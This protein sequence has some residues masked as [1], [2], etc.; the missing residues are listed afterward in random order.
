MK[1]IFACVLALCV[2]AAMLG[3]SL[4]VSNRDAAAEAVLEEA[5]VTEPA[6]AGDTGAGDTGAA[7]VDTSAATGDTGAATGDTGT[8]DTGA[9]AGDTGTGDTGTAAGDTGTATGD[10]GTGDTGTAAGDAG[11]STGVEA[12]AGDSG[13]ADAG[14]GDTQAGEADAGETVTDGSAEPDPTGD[15]A[16]TDGTEDTGETTDGD[17]AVA[18]DEGLVEPAEEE[19][20][21]LPEA[22]VGS[23]PAWIQEGAHRHYGELGELLP[24]AMGSG[25]A[26]VLCTASVIELTGYSVDSL[27]GVSFGVDRDALGGY[28]SGRSVIVSKLNPSGDSKSGVVFVWVGYPESAPTGGDALGEELDLSDEEDVLETEIMVRAE[29]YVAEEACAPVF[30]LVACPALGEGVTYAVQVNGGAAQSIAGD[31]YAPTASGEYRF[32]V[33]DAG[34]TLLAQSIP[35]TVNFAARETAPVATPDEEEGETADTGETD[36]GDTLLT[37]EAQ[38]G[39][40]SLAEAVGEEPTPELTVRAY[41]YTEGVSTG[42]TPVFA[43]SGAP[44]EGGYSYGVSVNGGSVVPLLTDQ[45]APTSSGEFTFVFFLL[46]ADGQTVGQSTSYHV[47]LD[48]AEAE[49]TGEAWMAS[50]DGKV[51]GTLGSLLRAA[52]GSG[53]VYLLTTSVLAVS[54][55]A[56]DGVKVAPDPDLYGSDYGVVTSAVSPDGERAE[57][58][59]YVWLGVDVDAMAFLMASAFSAPTFTIDAVSIGG[60]ALASGMWVNGKAAV[61]FTVTDTDVNTYTYEISL[62][63]GVTFQAFGEGGK[64]GKLSTPPTSG[65]SYA[66]VFRLTAVSDPAN[67]VTTAPCTVNYDAESPTLLCQTGENSTLTFYAGDGYS[68]FGGKE[69]NVTFNATASPISWTAKLAAQGAGV[70]T[71]SVRYSSAGVIAGGTLAVRDQAGNVTV[72]STDI[73]ISGQ[74]GGGGGRGGSG[75]G[76]RGGSV[77]RTIYHAASAYTTV[78]AYDGVDL[79]VETGEMDV[80]TIGAQQL[81]LTLMPDGVQDE[82]LPFQAALADWGGGA[83]DPDTLVLTASDGETQG[84][85]CVWTF[86]GTVY[87]RLAASGVDYMVFTVGDKAVAIS[88]AGFTGGLR[89]NM[90]R[91]AGLSS[92]AFVYTV[93]MSASGS[94]ALDVTV[95][96]QT[97]T[98]TANENSDFYY[99]DVYCGTLDMLNQPFGQEGTQSAAAQDRQG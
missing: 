35:Y 89:Y 81:D 44:A 22:D 43:L 72:W 83:G 19:L 14:T 69:N 82:V 29:N 24:M 10:T 39:E 56:L 16:V 55:S 33:L 80:L 17:Q 95:E 36:V 75:G 5:A 3:T 2:A 47:I 61:T 46:D 48:Y 84:G 94:V 70:Y 41:D 65:S 93:R 66:L 38:E 45:Y 28:A 11:E 12:G 49:Q 31:S 86:T 4:R 34:G 6:T 68:G 88:T 18:E 77:G 85:A 58:I 53:T 26:V 25:V 59:T 15:E 51:F 64:L 30:T 23:G 97:Y 67:T 71:Y 76:G 74:G 32:A 63:G 52:G 20:A 73:I 8:G 9:A 87:K 7:T 79:V 60:K 42:T 27:R 92:R 50:G 21:V 40:V 98:L 62:D 57:G 91:A 78:T 37:Q 54:S 96:G 1:K 90:Y 13:T 99:Y